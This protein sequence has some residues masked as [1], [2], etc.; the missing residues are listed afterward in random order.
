[1][2]DSLSNPK[3]APV[4]FHERPKLSNTKSFR[5]NKGNGLSPPK[6]D[7]AL[8]KP[9]NEQDDDEDFERAEDIDSDEDYDGM[10]FTEDISMVEVIPAD[11]S[12]K[13]E[14]TME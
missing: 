10:P 13:M 7:L 4:N 11:S 14:I 2:V 6:L 3:K 12:D 5:P 1:M 9:T 8:C